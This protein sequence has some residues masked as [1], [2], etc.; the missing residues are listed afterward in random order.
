MLCVSRV[1]PAR[2]AK[3][4]IWR[5]VV[6][7]PGLPCLVNGV[8]LP[9]GHPIP[10]A[11]SAVSHVNGSLRFI[12]N[13]MNSWGCGVGGC[14]GSPF[15]VIRS[16]LMILVYWSFFVIFVASYPVQCRLTRS[17]PINSWFGSLG[18]KPLFPAGEDALFVWHCI[19][20]IKC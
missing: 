9:Q 1:V 11:K 16:T 7:L 6:S 14:L 17:S 3:V 12:K 2:R 18:T 15:D 10:R 19:D 8:S 13:C 4:F 20:F 5:K